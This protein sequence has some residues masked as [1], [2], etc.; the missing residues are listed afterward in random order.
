MLGCKLHLKNQFCEIELGL[1]FSPF[2]MVLFGLIGYVR[3]F[4]ST[5]DITKLL[6]INECKTHLVC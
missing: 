4:I 5:K 2:K 1:K 6:Y 3:D